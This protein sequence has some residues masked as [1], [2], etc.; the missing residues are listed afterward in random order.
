MLRA[1]FQIRMFSKQSVESITHENIPSSMVL[2]ISFLIKRV[3]IK[4]KFKLEN[5]SFNHTKI[6]LFEY[7]IFTKTSAEK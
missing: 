1:L 2:K 3:H 4:R 7:F 6:S 5:C